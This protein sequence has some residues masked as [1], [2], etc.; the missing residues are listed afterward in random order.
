MIKICHLNFWLSYVN[1]LFYK[2]FS[3]FQKLTKEV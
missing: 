2:A 1:Y 3:I